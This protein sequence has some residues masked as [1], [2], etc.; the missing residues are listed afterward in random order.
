MRRTKLTNDK[1]LLCFR[2]PRG[3]D[4]I[5]CLPRPPLLAAHH[6]P[7]PTSPSLPPSFIRTNRSCK[8]RGSSCVTI[9]DYITRVPKSGKCS[10]ERY[11]FFF[12]GVINKISHDKKPSDQG[13]TFLE[14][15]G[16]RGWDKKSRL[17]APRCFTAHHRPLPNSPSLPASNFGPTP[18]VSI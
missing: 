1:A 5:S 2:G 8:H 9:L 14:C 10:V 15:R 13:Q 16:P 18:N 3:W 4:K 6:R 7:L 11:V 17:R 12:L